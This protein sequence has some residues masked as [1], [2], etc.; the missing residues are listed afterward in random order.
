MRACLPKTLNF[1]LHTPIP[2]PPDPPQKKM[3]TYCERI[4]PRW[5]SEVE[6]KGS[7]RSN[8]SAHGMRK[9]AGQTTS[10]EPSFIKQL[11]IAIACKEIGHINK[12]KYHALF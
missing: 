3:E 10:I 11:A 5:I 2:P 4:L 7:Q 12:L 9:T 6:H 8:S 1:N